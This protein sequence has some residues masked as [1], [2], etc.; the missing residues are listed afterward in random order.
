MEGV[1]EKTCFRIPW[2]LSVCPVN[3]C[4]ITQQIKSWEGYSR[5]EMIAIKCRNQ[6][7]TGNLVANT[8]EVFPPIQKWSGIF[9]RKELTLDCFSILVPF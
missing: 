4:N 5:L 3:G 1:A 8:S 2:V 7:K 6:L 9:R